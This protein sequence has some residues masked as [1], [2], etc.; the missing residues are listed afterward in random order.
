MTA[1]AQRPAWALTGAELLTELDAAQA[2]LSRVQAR[3][4]E[5]LG[6]L[7][8]LGHAKELGARDTTEL[9]ALRHRLDPAVVRRDIRN[10]RALASYPVVSASLHGHPDTATDA[11]ADAD[12]DA[13]PVPAGVAGS[14]GGDAVAGEAGQ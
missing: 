13:G 2:I 6:C 1:I 14:A 10:A 8:D 4:L 12:A 7:D 9:V 5:L 3:R 11:D